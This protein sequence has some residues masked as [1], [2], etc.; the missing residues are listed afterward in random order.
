MSDGN[1][2]RLSIRT[3]T[4]SSYPS[5]AGEPLRHELGIVA[6]AVEE[7]HAVQVVALHHGPSSALRGVHL[8][9]VIPGPP[10]PMVSACTERVF[11]PSCNSMTRRTTALITSASSPDAAPSGNPTRKLRT[12]RNRWVNEN[13][14]VDRQHVYSPPATRR[15]L[16]KHKQPCRSATEIIACRIVLSACCRGYP[17]FPR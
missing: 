7:N 6:A 16:N 2:T 13:E 12:A 3:V 17:F 15:A 4:S 11:N 1:G 5:T 14:Q 8:V 10:W 9:V